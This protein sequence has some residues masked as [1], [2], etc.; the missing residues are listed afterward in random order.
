MEIKTTQRWFFLWSIL[1]LSS[2]S[3]ESEFL[4]CLE[5]LLAILEN[6]NGEVRAF[7]PPLMDLGLPTL[8]VSLLTSEMGILVDEKKHERY[9]LFFT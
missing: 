7:L 1:S 4:Q 9:M 5:F 3:I 2:W 8:L 6:E